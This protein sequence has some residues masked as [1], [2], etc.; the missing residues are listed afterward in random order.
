MLKGFVLKDLYLKC[1]KGIKLN[2]IGLFSSGIYL[3]DEAENIYMLHDSDYGLIPFGIGIKDFKETIKPKSIPLNSNIYIDNYHLYI[4]ELI[5]ELTKKELEEKENKLD[6]NEYLKIIKEK[7]KEI[8]K[9]IF[10]NLVIDDKENIYSKKLKKA[11]NKEINVDEIIGLGPG[12][13][14]SGDD[15]LVGYLYSLNDENEFNELKEKILRIVDKNTNQISSTYLKAV[16]DK[17]RFSLFDDIIY[18]YDKESLLIS[19]DKLF[20]VGSNSG[21]D[22]LVGMLYTK[23]KG[24][25]DD[26]Y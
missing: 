1:S 17:K 19:L 9:G 26:K 13:T 15:F 7:L 24:I 8:D 12:L 11:L 5:I 20:K 10:K 23:M 25:N 18:P 2:I 21:V 3:K 22:I 14:P 6:L 16:L 4:N